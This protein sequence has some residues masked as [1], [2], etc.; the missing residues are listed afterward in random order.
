MS[1]C[2]DYDW[3]SCDNSWDEDYCE[4]PKRKKHHK[5]KQHDSCWDYSY[6]SCDVV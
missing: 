4:R 5:R 6:S 3:N 1:Y 2:G